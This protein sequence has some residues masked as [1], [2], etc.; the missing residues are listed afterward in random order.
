MTTVPD[1]AVTRLISYFKHQAGKDR[2][3]IKKMVQ[4]G[5]DGLLGVLDGMTEE[6]ATF[7]PSADTWSVLEVLEHVATAKR[8][9]AR[10]CAGLA[11]GETYEGV[12]PDEERVTIQDGLSRMS[13]G[14]LDE[15]RS[16]TEASHREQ[17][18]FIASLSPEADVEARYKHFI[19]G[20]LNCREWAVFQ[21]VHDA[22]HGNQI[23]QVKAA[24]GYPG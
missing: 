7:K 12:G 18:A 5:H 15:A 1:D 8:E 6:Q 20:A 11:R 21:R 10:L 4:E 14:S 23:E 16:T 22:D 3:A 24:P 19:F 13:F 9:I 2:E 17:L